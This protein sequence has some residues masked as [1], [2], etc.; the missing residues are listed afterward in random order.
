MT[1]STLHDFLADQEYETTTEVILDL[2]LTNQTQTLIN[3]GQLLQ[4]TKA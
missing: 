2:T 4:Q 3:H 1:K